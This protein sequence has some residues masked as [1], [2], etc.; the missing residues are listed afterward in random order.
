MKTFNSL[1][2]V[3]IPLLIY[4]TAW[5]KEKTA[6]LVELALKKGFR[7]IDTACQP[8][9]YNEPLVGEG[10]ARAY[11]TGVQRSDLY[12]QTKFTPFRGQDPNDCPY[13]PQDNIVDQI[14]TSLSVSLKNLKTDYLD[15]LVLHSPLQTWEDN[16]RAWAV[17]ESFVNDGFVKQIGISNCYD[18]KLF[19]RLF[20]E[21][22]VKPSL[23]QNRFY[24][25]TDYDKELRAF[26]N[27]QGV[28]YQCFW[29]VN[30]N[31]HIWKDPFVIELAGKHVKTA[32]QIYFRTLIHEKVH[33]LYGTTNPD[34][35]EEVMDLLNF[36]IEIEHLEKIKEIGAY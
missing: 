9:H 4:G 3:N 13:N 11:K 25:E 7:G 10:I 22:K 35:M 14:K 12:I 8:K 26:C 17:L 28:Y 32:L 5:K 29:T 6:E 33:P 15:S 23:L 34:H 19:K 27:E 1:S 16:Q 30:A 18:P 2:N 31:P 21:A 20:N 36:Q 24:N